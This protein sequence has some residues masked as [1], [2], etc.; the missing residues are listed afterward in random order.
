LMWCAYVSGDD[1]ILR[2]TN[3]TAERERVFRKLAH[4]LGHH[5]TYRSGVLW[6]AAQFGVSTI[7]GN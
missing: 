5:H 1:T 6:C 7:W 4:R 2:T 3:V